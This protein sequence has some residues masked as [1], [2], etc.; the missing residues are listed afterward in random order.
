M[1]WSGI[2]SGFEL[3]LGLGVDPSGEQTGQC[4]SIRVG[5]HRARRC[6]MV[7]DSR[8]QV[9]HRIVDLVLL[10]GEALNRVLYRI[11]QIPAPRVRIIRTIGECNTGDKMTDRCVPHYYSQAE[12]NISPVCHSLAC[13]IGY[14]SP[15]PQ[16]H[17]QLSNCTH[18]PIHSQKQPEE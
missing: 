8:N 6:M 17:S 10:H 3:A 14:N 16:S 15:V 4:S 9:V 12:A 18:C 7:G 5:D 13:N 1:V 11:S 2:S